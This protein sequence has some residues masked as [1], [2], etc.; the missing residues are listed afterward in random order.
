MDLYVEP[1]R[2]PELLED[3]RLMVEP[4]AARN[5]NSLR[6]CCPAEIT[7]VQRD[8]T[9]LKQSLLNL[10]S[11][12]A[13][14]TR[15]GQVALQV[16]RNAASPPK[17]HFVVSDT[18]IGMTE[19]Q[20]ARLFQAF[21][22]GDSST[23]RK[24]GGTGLGLVI[25]RSVPRLLGGDVTLHN[26]AGEGSQFTLTLPDAGPA[27]PALDA[28]HA[29]PGEGAA[30]A[31][32][33]VIDDDVAARRIIGAHL[34]REGYRVR[35]A[36]GGAAALELARRAPPDAITLDIIMPHPDG[37]S[38]LQA[39]KADPRPRTD[40]G[41]AGQ[42]HTRSRPGVCPGRGGGG[43][44]AGG[45][46]GTDRRPALASVARQRADRADRR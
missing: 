7:T 15:D 32:V 40:P 8:A 24:Y 39:L 29:G 6:I 11:N 5:G 35:Y 36:A 34:A 27:Q 21:S 16:H 22:Q 28:M 25:T 20:Q 1:V 46:G 14:F 30:L 3:V 44:Q 38:V 43:G 10:L 45:P 13:K 9:R 12:A 19:A 41:G 2:L 17:L 31:S 23:T 33:L 18:G 37:W 42:P 26:V 4:L